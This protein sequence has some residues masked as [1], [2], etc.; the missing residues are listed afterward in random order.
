MAATL[1]AAMAG[2]ANQTTVDN[3]L[4]DYIRQPG[5][6]VTSG[7][8]TAYI[9]TL[10]PAPTA[11]VDGMTIT[12]KPHATSGYAPTLN[13]NNLGALTIVK[14]DGTSINSGDII[15]NKPVSLVRVGSF[16]LFVTLM[17]LALKVYSEGMGLVQ[18]Q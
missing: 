9:V 15:V 7:T 1:E 3:M 12:I 5:Y 11:Y 13:V 10:N 4:K 17:N 8:S 16:F 6:A 18:S 14:Q 2:K